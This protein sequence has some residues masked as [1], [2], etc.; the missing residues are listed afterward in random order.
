[1]TK[2]DLDLAVAAARAALYARGYP[3]VPHLFSVDYRMRLYYDD[4]APRYSVTVEFQTD[5]VDDINLLPV[6]AGADKSHATKHYSLTLP[7]SSNSNPLDVEVSIYAAVTY[8]YTKD[9]QELLMAMGKIVEETETY[10]RSYL[11]CAAA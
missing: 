8:S 7:V 11:H 9:E 1:M 10:T 4:P 2:N 5:D 6:D 3:T